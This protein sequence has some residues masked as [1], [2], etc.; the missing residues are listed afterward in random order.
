MADAETFARECLHAY[1][2]Y[3]AL[4]ER[5]KDVNFKEVLGELAV[6]SREE[7]DYWARSSGVRGDTAQVRRLEVWSVRLVRAL[8]GVSMT[9]KYVL[10]RKRRRVRAYIQYVNSCTD[11]RDAQVVAV[12]ISRLNAIADRMTRSK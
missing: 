7:F 2:L 4:A 11:A 10:R 8:F 5:E 9:A 3:L 6:T 1:G 12:Y